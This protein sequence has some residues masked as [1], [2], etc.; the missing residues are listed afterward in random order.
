M[1]QKKDGIYAMV[2]GVEYPVRYVFTKSFSADDGVLQGLV[3]TS[4]LRVV[5]D[6]DKSFYLEYGGYP[7]PD[8]PN[9]LWKRIVGY[10]I[11]PGVEDGIRFEGE[12][13]F[14]VFKPGTIDEIAKIA[15][16]GRADGLPLY[17][18]NVCVLYRTSDM[19]ILGVRRIDPH[20][21]VINVDGTPL[22]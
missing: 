22:Q 6:V 13:D 4:F 20:I 17:S 3:E 10:R 7:Y 11:I 21:T 12:S 14:C 18:M 9:D 15:K 1:D 19:K 2:N 5:Q 16:G 8:C